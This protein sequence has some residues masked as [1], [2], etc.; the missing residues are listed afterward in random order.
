MKIV[1]FKSY[2][3]RYLFFTIVIGLVFIIVQLFIF[4]DEVYEVLIN[5]VEDVQSNLLYTIADELECNLSQLQMRIVNISNEISKYYDIQNPDLSEYLLR[6]QNEYPEFN[7]GLYL[8]DK[9]GLLLV[10]TYFRG[11]RRGKDFSFREYYKE[12]I[13]KKQAFISEMYFSSLDHGNPCIMVVAPIL[14]EFGDMKG[15]VSGSINLKIDNLFAHKIEGFNQKNFYFTIYSQEGYILTHPDNDFIG[16]RIQISD[17]LNQTE[18]IDFKDRKV[19]RI[20][21]L[22]PLNK[23]YLTI[24]N[25]IDVKEILM[26]KISHLYVINNLILM[27]I[28]ISIISVFVIFCFRYIELYIK[29][30]SIFRKLTENQIQLPIS[31]FREFNQITDIISKQI[32]NYSELSKEKKQALVLKKNLI[33]NS[34]YPLII[35]DSKTFTIKTISDTALSFL[36]YE[37]YETENI[38]L[39]ELFFKDSLSNKKIFNDFLEK[40]DRSISE[41]DSYVFCPNNLRKYIKVKAKKDFYDNVECIFLSFNDIQNELNYKKNIKLLD[42]KFNKLLEIVEMPICIADMSGNII[43]RNNFFVNDFVDSKKTTLYTIFDLFNCFDEHRSLIDLFS[44]ISKQ[45]ILHKSI[46]VHKK[47]IND[48]NTDMYYLYWHYD[49]SENNVVKSVILIFSKKDIYNMR[50]DI[51]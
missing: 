49:I 51:L 30:I 27:I 31:R 8:F 21:K 32:N 19:K 5:N 28:I 22:L 4:R 44:D 48:S 1:S 29:N 25:T 39:I 15:L 11:N 10:E 24:N 6:K 33:N 26:I 47:E 13:N 23:W 2:F 38:S 16:K 3:F 34:I 40:L 46:L 35:V 12:L 42:N 45:F 17:L 43:Y 41:I 9:K 37:S 18:L 14:D 36:G 7:N 20:T 50:K